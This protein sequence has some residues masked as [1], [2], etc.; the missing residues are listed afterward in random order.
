MTARDPTGLTAHGWIG[1]PHP[2]TI[3]DWSPVTGGFQRTPPA[4]AKLHG[5]RLL[6]TRPAYPQRPMVDLLAEESMTPTG[7]PPTLTELEEAWA[8][9]ARLNA[10]L[11]SRSGAT[12]LKQACHFG[13]S[14]SSH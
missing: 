10:C 9:A 11:R 8:G 13:D 14:P 1:Q 4:R 6:D 3:G 5:V 2:E 12:G 7:Q